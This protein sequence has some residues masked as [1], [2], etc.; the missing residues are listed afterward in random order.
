MIDCLDYDQNYNED[1]SLLENKIGNI[2]KITFEESKDTSPTHS[3]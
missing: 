2:S 1:N 3:I